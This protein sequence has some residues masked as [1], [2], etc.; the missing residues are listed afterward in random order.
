MTWPAGKG[1]WWQRLL[2]RGVR[3]PAG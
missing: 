1:R 2:R 3:H